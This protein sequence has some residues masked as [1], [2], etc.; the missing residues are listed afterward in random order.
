MRGFVLVAVLVFL[1]ILSL[2]VIDVLAGTGWM[3]REL[4][5]AFVLTDMDGQAVK[6]LLELGL[7]EDLNCLIE[8]V[9][10]HRLVGYEKSWWD[11]HACAGTNGENGK[12]EYYFIKELL[13]VDKCRS[14]KNQ[15]NQGEAPGTYRETLLYLSTLTNNMRVIRQVVLTAPSG[16]APDCDH[17]IKEVKRQIINEMRLA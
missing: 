6:V 8:P 1:Q 11:A 3:R 13:S 5:A 4:T 14:I 16:V 17:P 10:S 7:R 2:V 9:A 12:Y 15:Y